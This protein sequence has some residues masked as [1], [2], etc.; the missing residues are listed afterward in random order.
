M[1]PSQARNRRGQTL[2]LFVLFLLALVGIL[3][4]TLDF[5]FVLLSR[6]TMQTAVN[7]GALEGARNIDRRGRMEAREVIQNVFDDDLDPRDNLTTLGVGPEHTLVQRDES[8]RTRLGEGTDASAL[9]ANR[10]EYVY[11]P[12]SELNTDNEI[13]GDLVAG[14]YQETA[15]SHA[16]LS[17]YQRQDFSASLQGQ[18]FLARIRRTPQRVGVA[19]PL[20]RIAGISSSGDGSPLLVGHLV[21][22]IPNSTGDFDI[23]RDGVTI[24]ATA[25]AD[26]RPIVYVGSAVSDALYSATS[27]GRYPDAEFHVL[28]ST[29][30]RLGDVV[31]VGV[32]VDEPDV[33]TGYVAALFNYNEHDY[34]VGFMLNINASDTES[35]KP[36]ASPRL[37]DAMQTLNELSPE[38]RDAVLARHRE[39]AQEENSV[40][41]RLPVLVR[42]IP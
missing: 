4:L 37:H 13:H 10:H 39:L 25:I 26:N 19:N 17:D 11:R 16:E 14:D 33:P 3:A 30:H 24:R 41:A 1:G 42:A 23:R 29:P 21:P 5:G 9:L 40:L 15:D 28:D 22:F 6:R 2:I 12:A 7:T 8:E 27:Y 35:R 20:D 34:V 32:A 18:A 36:N 38:V 31:S